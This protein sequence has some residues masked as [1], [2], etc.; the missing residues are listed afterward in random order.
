L[1]AR[2]A[3]R[4]LT[5]PDATA[6]DRVHRDTPIR[7]I[8]QSKIRGLLRCFQIRFQFVLQRDICCK[9]PQ[10][11]KVMHLFVARK[12]EMAKPRE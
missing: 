10:R 2:A 11:T 6:V 12:L 3:A 4:A 7:F 1:A 5:L 8:S 9:R